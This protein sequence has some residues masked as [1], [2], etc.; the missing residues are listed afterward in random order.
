MVFSIFCS[1]SADSSQ[2]KGC[3]DICTQTIQVK[4]GCGPL[5]EACLPALVFDACRPSWFVVLLPPELASS[6]WESQHLC[7][8]ST[9]EWGGITAACAAIKCEPFP[10]QVNCMHALEQATQE[11]ILTKSQLAQYSLHC[12][13]FVA[14]LNYNMSVFSLIL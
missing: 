10:Y 1:T 14:L 6:Y 12:D 3:E 2:L 8:R 9:E 13:F 7:R 11:G 5:L 4:S